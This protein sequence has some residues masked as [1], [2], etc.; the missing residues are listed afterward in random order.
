MGIKTQAAT[1]YLMV[2]GFV[3]VILL[4][5]I[6]FYVKYSHESEDSIINAKIDAITNEIIKAAEQVYS[7]GEGSQTTISVDMPKN[8]KMIQF[9]ENEII[10]TVINSKGDESEIAKV[11]NVNLNGI[12]S[13]VPGTKKI[14]IKSLGNFVT[15]Y[16]E[17]N[18]GSERCGDDFECSYFIEDYQEGSG[19]VLE[20]NNNQWG[21]K[22]VCDIGCSDNICI[23]CQDED[24]KCGSAEECSPDEECIMTCNN[25]NWE[26]EAACTEDAPVCIETTGITQCVE[27]DSGQKC[28][29]GE[30]CNTGGS[31]DECILDC[32]NNEWV[33]FQECNQL[34]NL[35]CDDLPPPICA[36]ICNPGEQRCG[37]GEEECN[38][39]FE[40]CI[41]E[42]S[43]EFDWELSSSCDPGYVCE[44]MAGEYECVLQGAA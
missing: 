17:C 15:V 39:G 3:M 33:L 31:D 6:Y 21:Y 5:G 27:C 23:A 9:I 30:E 36:P 12:I 16:I 14:N 35:M 20:C 26:V 11:S 19:C 24:T 22:E 8:V 34:P 40:E 7:Y 38:P 28:G 25:G 10:F 4:P 42:C 37:Y 2:I 29:L 41:M 1:E 43:P 44:E 18:T 13:L 32:Q